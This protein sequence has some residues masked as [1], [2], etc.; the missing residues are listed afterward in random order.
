MNR[1]ELAQ[2]AQTV[3]HRDLRN[4]AREGHPAG[5]VFLPSELLYAIKALPEPAMRYIPRIGETIYGVPVIRFESD[6]MSLYFLAS[7]HYSNGRP[8]TPKVHH[9]PYYYNP[10]EVTNYGING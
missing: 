8:G 9:R 3:I 7:A 4:R 6:D 10:K 5:A 1:M 2:H